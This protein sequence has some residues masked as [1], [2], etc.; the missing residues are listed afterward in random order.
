MK[1]ALMQ[2]N[3]VSDKAAN[4][5]QARDLITRAVD[6]EG[7]DWV[8]LPEHFDWSGGS[9]ADK[10]ANADSP[11]SGPAFDFAQEIAARYKIWVHAGSF[12]VR[13]EGENRIYNTTVAFNRDGKPV[14]RYEKIH[15]FDITAPDGKVYNESATVKPGHNVVTYDCE[16]LTVGCSICYD[17]RFPE[18][19]Q[20]L[21]AHGADIIALPAA[22]TLQTGKDHW[23][24]LAR[25]RA[26]ETQCY[27]VACAQTGS[28]STGAEVRQTYGHSL[29]VDP[30]GHVVAKASD[31]VGF[32]ATRLDPALIK[33]VR[34]MIPVATHKV[35]GT[36]TRA[37]VGKAA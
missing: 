28:F 11:K 9:S 12:M 30:W 18:L 36:G 7:P 31:G 34:G 14:A 6:L 16:G 5:A 25:A 21:Q 3:S 33:R 17:I 35:L 10:L 27:F 19:F 29:V 13:V 24:V 15:L 32:I 8:C 37:S 4:I 23:E 1:I 20:A 2:M 22:F 26:I